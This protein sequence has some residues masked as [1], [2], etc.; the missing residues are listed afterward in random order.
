VESMFAQ[1]APDVSERLCGGWLAVSSRNAPLRIGVTANTEGEVRA[2]FNQALIAWE[3][4]LQS[5]ASNDDQ[6]ERRCQ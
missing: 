1:I 2:A 4:I 5:E 6:T 3:A